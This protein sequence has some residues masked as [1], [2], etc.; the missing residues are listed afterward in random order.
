MPDSH[1]GRISVI[2]EPSKRA[3]EIMATKYTEKQLNSIDKSLLVTMFLGLPEQFE[4]LSDKLTS[5]DK[6]VSW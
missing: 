1:N 6:S 2:M 5:M 3:F 4:A